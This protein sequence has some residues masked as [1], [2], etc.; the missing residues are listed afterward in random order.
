MNEKTKDELLDELKN[1]WKLK[2]LNFESIEGLSLNYYL[3]IEDY[4]E[5]K[6]KKSLLYFYQTHVIPQPF[7]WEIDKPKIVVLAKNPTY[8]I[9]REENETNELLK[10]SKYSIEDIICNHGNDLLFSKELEDFLENDEMCTKNWWLET[11]DSLVSSGHELNDI[12]GKVGIFNLC[13][14]HSKE[15]FDVPK[16]I[17]NEGETLLPTQKRLQTY[18]KKLLEDK[19]I[20]VI[21]IWGETEWRK[22]LGNKYFNRDRLLIVNANKN[23]KKTRNRFISKSGNYDAKKD[24]IMKCLE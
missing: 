2:T 3:S 19:K 1:S 8:N 24:E 14:Y 10:C 21:I 11:L 7:F 4:D 6:D 20:F 16:D 17:L 23:N 13:G 15:Y 5:L 18:L 9:N 12:M 22:F